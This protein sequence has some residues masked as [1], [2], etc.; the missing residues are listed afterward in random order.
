KLPL[1]L[2]D[3]GNPVRYRNVWVRE[4]GAPS[5]PEFYLADAVLDSYSGTYDN[6]VVTRLDG[7]LLLTFSGVTS[8][9]FAESPTRFFS[10]VVDI[11]AE[12]DPAEKTI[13]V[14]VG[15]EGGS[16]KKKK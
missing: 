1:A 4:L 15:E 13:Q 10:K 11:Q 7:R 2:Q 12:F 14:S 5:K 8:E 6:Y 16:K 9:L 3:H